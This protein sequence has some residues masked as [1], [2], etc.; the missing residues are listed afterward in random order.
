MLKSCIFD[1]NPYTNPSRIVK[2]AQASVQR[3]HTSYNAKTF[4]PNPRSPNHG[5]VQHLVHGKQSILTRCIISTIN[6]DFCRK[7]VEMAAQS[8]PSEVFRVRALQRAAK[9]IDQL[10]ESVVSGQEA[11]KV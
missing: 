7:E 5:L 11:M 9:I 8:V 6:C 3:R 4:I 2:H 10:P 1:R